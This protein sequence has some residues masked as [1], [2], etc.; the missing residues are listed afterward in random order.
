MYDGITFNGKHSTR[1]LGLTI[2]EK[3]IGNPE[4]EK[5]LVKVPFSDFEYDFSKLYGEQEFSTREL[6]YTFNVYDRRTHTKEQMNRLKIRA[7]NHFM[8]PNEMI[9]LYDDQIPS[10]HFLAE[11][12]KEPSFKEVRGLGTLTVVF[13][14]YKFKIYNVAEG[15]DE[16]DIFDFEYSIAQHT[17]LNV[18]G[19]R[20]IVLINESFRSSSVKI[21][22]DSEFKITL[23]NTTF[24]VSAGSTES[25]SFRLSKGINDLKIVGSG[26][27]EFIWHKELI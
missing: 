9:P 3:E 13:T 1:D 14:A 23:N 22:C 15:N 18:K 19:S 11:V 10:F 25:Y 27:I 6:S 20:E 2:K 7:L 26:R 16:W 4:K 21:V 17:S 8:E 12:R 5:V 24:T